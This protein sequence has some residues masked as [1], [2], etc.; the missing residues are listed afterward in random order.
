MHQRFTDL[1]I[2]SQGFTTQGYES[3]LW[4]PPGYEPDER[5]ATQ[6]PSDPDKPTTEGFAMMQ[7]QCVWLSNDSQTI[8]EI[9]S[10]HLND[11]EHAFY[12]DLRRTFSAFAEETHGLERT[13]LYE[14]KQRPQHI[15]AMDTASIIREHTDA[16]Y[17][18]KLSYHAGIRA[19][20]TEPPGDKE[21]RAVQENWPDL[22][23]TVRKYVIARMLPQAYRRQERQWS[24]DEIQELT[25]ECSDLPNPESAIAGTLRPQLINIARYLELYV[26]ARKQEVS[27]SDYWRLYPADLGASV[28]G[29]GA[30]LRLAHGVAV[31]ASELFERPD[32]KVVDQLFRCTNSP[33][34]STAF[35][36][37]EQ[38]CDL[39]KVA[40][41]VN[42]LRERRMA[43][44]MAKLAMQGVSYLH[45][46]GLLHIE[47][48]RRALER[49]TQ[50]R[51]LNHREHLAMICGQ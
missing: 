16:I 20:S 23:Q 18:Q 41:L 36:K 24:D 33:V 31:S 12:T 22:T 3:G 29:I 19:Y 21:L 13:V 14:G 15:L 40:V 48:S 2:P 30:H 28:E 35:T 10:T 7:S 39:Q 43:S 42:R 32:K 6:L 4:C 26:Q 46:S 27:P 50:E 5:M 25:E 11:P 44:L 9:S 47:V 1:Y 17:L 34:F 51:K 45:M 37:T 8:V 38:L 49:I